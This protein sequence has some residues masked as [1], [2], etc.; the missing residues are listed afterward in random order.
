MVFQRAALS[1]DTDWAGNKVETA[2]RVVHKPTGTTATASE[3]RSQWQNRSLALERLRNKLQ[4]SR[5]QQKERIATKTPPKA[6]RARLNSKKSQS[7][8]KQNR[9]NV[10]RGDW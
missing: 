2:V 8:K 3:R 5:V 9:G 4:A 10:K 6:T 7:L 1:H